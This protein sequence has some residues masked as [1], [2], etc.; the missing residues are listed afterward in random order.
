LTEKEMMDLLVKT[1]EEHHWLIHRRL[2]ER[3]VYDY[4]SPVAV[5][6]QEFWR[7]LKL[8]LEKESL[9]ETV[10]STV[11]R[12][13]ERDSQKA[14]ESFGRKYSIHPELKENVEKFVK[15][16]YDIYNTRYKGEIM[17]FYLYLERIRDK[18]YV[19]RRLREIERMEKA[20]EAK[21]G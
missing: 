6:Q 12:D 13:I 8:K 18:V 14:A 19:D 5:L 17:K 4:T 16:L 3:S 1:L 9:I 10:S 2:E 15:W 7:S 20:R 11:I 21:G